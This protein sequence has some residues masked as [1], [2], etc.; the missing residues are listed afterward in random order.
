MCSYGQTS[1]RNL[2]GG[3]EWISE[4]GVHQRKPLLELKYLLGFVGHLHVGN[5]SISHRYRQH[6]PLHFY[7]W[8]KPLPVLWA[9]CRYTTRDICRN[10]KTQTQAQSFRTIHTY[11]EW[12]QTYTHHHA[13]AC[14]CVCL[15]V[16]VLAWIQEYIRQIMQSLNSC[17]D[18]GNKRWDILHSLLHKAL[19]RCSLLP[20]PHAML[21]LEGA[22]PFPS[23][24]THTCL[25]SP[26][27]Q[28]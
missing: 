5:G 8:H 25:K 20:I 27:S 11:T 19:V 2:R 24:L 17:T 1:V 14:V 12:V 26:W 22:P 16:C 9:R 6:P 3:H 21:R 23:P 7:A 15:C 28:S 13:Q 4:P 10:N 18:T